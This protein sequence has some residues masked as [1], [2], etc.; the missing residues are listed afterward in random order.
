MR[1]TRSTASKFL[2]RPQSS[3][4]L[5]RAVA[6]SECISAQ[7]AARP[8]IGRPML[9]RR[10]SGWQSVHLPTQPLRH[11]PCRYSS[12]QSISGCSLTKRWGISKAFQAAEMSMNRRGTLAEVGAR[13]RLTWLSA[14]ARS[15]FD[16][17]P[18]FGSVLHIY[19]RGWAESRVLSLTD[20]PEVDQRIGPALAVSLGTSGRLKPHSRVEPNRLSVLFIYVG[21]KIRTDAQRVSDK[22]TPHTG[23]SMRRINKQRLHMATAKQHESNRPVL[24]VYCN[25]ER[26]PGQKAGHLLLDITAVVW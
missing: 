14:A 2:E 13:Q 25:P 20:I 12:N 16:V 15:D 3:F 18:R 21:G 4:A 22:G 26:G 24:A 8:S 23:S 11:L 5:P 1:S 10:G 17:A 6:R 19:R 7:L 9:R